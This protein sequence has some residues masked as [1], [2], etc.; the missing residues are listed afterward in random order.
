VSEPD[1]ARER[2]LEEIRQTYAGYREQGRERLW[3]P[4]N[5]GYARMSRDRDQA[6]V[7]LVARSLPSGGSALDIGCGPG[8]LADLVRGHVREVSWTG[9]DLLPEA[10]AEAKRMN[11]WASWVEASADRLPFP[12]ASFDVVVASTLFSSLPSDRLER[13]VADEIARVLVPDGWLVWYDLRYSNPRN[14]AVHGVSRTRVN[15]LFPDWVAE[16]RSITLAPPIARH[17]G[18]LTGPVYAALEAIAPVRSHLV[19]RL[20]R[21]PDEPTS[22][23]VAAARDR[24]LRGSGR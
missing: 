22:P 1:A 5:R 2:D 3:D 16:L 14:R 9:A 24:E 15:E 13:A 21:P 8:H 18:W 17:L 4:R 19:G 7:E 11:P 20:R 23:E 12:A 10:I 6:L